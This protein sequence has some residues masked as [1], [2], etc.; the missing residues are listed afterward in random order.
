MFVQSQGTS[1]TSRKGVTQSHLTESSIKAWQEEKINNEE[2][3]S[4]HDDHNSHNSVIS[5]KK[6][7]VQTNKET[8]PEVR[9][10]SRKNIIL[11]IHWFC[12]K[13]ADTSWLHPHHILLY[14]WITPKVLE[15]NNFM[16]RVNFSFHYSPGIHSFALTNQQIKFKSTSSPNLSC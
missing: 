15:S 10:L 7:C 9:S 12:V 3:A 14:V 1:P 8:Q 16:K 6:L 4:W 11:K 2:V 13:N 5:F